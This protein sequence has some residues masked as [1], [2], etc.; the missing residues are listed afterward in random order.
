MPGPTL[1]VA[2]NLVPVD[3]KEDLSNIVP[4]DYI[5]EWFKQRVN[6]TGIGNRVLILKSDTG[7]GKS[8]VFPAHL[9]K[10]LSGV[11]PRAKIAVSQPRVLTA[12]S[13]VREE[14]IGTGYYPYLKLGENI[15]WKTGSSRKT[16][17]FGLTY[18]TVDSLAM[19]LRTRT[20]EQIMENYQVIVMDEVHELGLGLTYV[21]YMLKNFLLRNKDNPKLPF[22]VATSA[23]FDVDKYMRYFNVNFTSVIQV[24]G[25]TYPK[26]EHF[27]DDGLR[28]RRSNGP[29]TD[30]RTF[31]EARH[32]RGFGCVGQPRHA[33][34]YV[35]RAAPVG[36]PANR[37][38]GN[39][40]E[41]QTGR[42]GAS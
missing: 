42:F 29:R 1:L 27:A 10:W 26:H 9:Y 4:I 21:M 35:G 11:N 39:D 19:Q 14:L 17:D 36:V 24:T 40:D 5:I 22:V 15:G 33:R 32:L 20:D 12:I 16:V 6:K 8:T 3:K 28:F 7:S 2:G 30:H 31:S 18:M 23:T 37:R 41:D 13:I 38:P 25:S 34:R